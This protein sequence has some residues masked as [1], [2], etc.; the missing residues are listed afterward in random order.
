MESQEVVTYTYNLC[1]GSAPLQF[2]IVVE[3]EADRPNHYTFSL[4]MKAGHVERTLCETIT[5][6]LS[7]DP[8]RL[9]FSVFVFPPRSS[10]PAGC[11][12][13][14]RVWLRT[15]EIDHR[16]FGD[17]DLWVGRDP[18]FRSI[19]DASFAILRNATQ[20]MLIYQ[21]VVGRAHVSF[22]IRWQLVEV[23]LYSLSLDYEA[24]GAGRILFD[25]YEL[26]LDCEPQTVSF[27]IYSI[28]VS[29]TPAGASHRLRCWLRTPHVFPSPTSSV[30]SQPAES[31]IYQRLWK[32]DDFK[33]G[34]KLN[35]EALGNK[36]SMGIQ[37][38]VSPHFDRDTLS[39]YQGRRRSRLPPHGDV[40]SPGSPHHIVNDR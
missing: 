28:P 40:A 37:D 33:L 3:A 17:N 26:R 1:A 23:G 14:L 34:A 22:I 6:R 11:L 7:I 39:I 8:R 18:D 19:G 13:N 15:G 20:D 2:F 9:N 36:L 30:T 24:G 38:P 12:Y 4:S 16:L 25:N 35:F 32:C 29:S 5:M 31:Y 21:A 27:M 10:L